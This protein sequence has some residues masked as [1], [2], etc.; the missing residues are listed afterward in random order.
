MLDAVDM[1]EGSRTRGLNRIAALG[2]KL[3]EKVLFLG[4]GTPRTTT[5]AEIPIQ[6]VSWGW[7]Y[8]IVVILVVDQ[9][10]LWFSLLLL[11]VA[12]LFLP[13]CRFFGFD[14]SVRE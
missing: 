14:G 4:W 2:A 5:R 10:L 7:G 3:V 8:H 1:V 6:R 11:L 9:C 13:F 12:S